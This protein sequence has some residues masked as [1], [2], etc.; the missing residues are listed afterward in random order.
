[1][2]RPEGRRPPGR[3]K[4]RW[5]GNIIVNLQKVERGGTD[6]IVVGEDRD[7]WRALVNAVMNRSVP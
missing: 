3:P 6:W 2:G 1:M 5:K 7:K 4:C